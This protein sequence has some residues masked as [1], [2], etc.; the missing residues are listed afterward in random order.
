MQPVVGISHGCTL[1]ARALFCGVGWGFERDTSH[2]ATGPSRRNLG[3]VGTPE[4]MGE[5]AMIC[6]TP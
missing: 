1:V 4:T 5:H 6:L 2:V 3:T